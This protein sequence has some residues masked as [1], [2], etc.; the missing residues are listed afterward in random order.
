VAAALIHSPQVVFLDE[1]TAGLDV[2]SAR[3][4]RSL[5]R[6]INRD[7][8]TVFLTTHNLAEAESLSHRILILVRGQLVAEG[9]AAEI[10]RQVE[11]T[12]SLSVRF[13]ADVSERMLRDACPDVRSISLVEGA[14]RLEVTDVHRATAQLL[15]FADEH[16]VRI[17]ELNTSTPSLED[18]FMTILKGDSGKEEAPP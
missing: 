10:R 15:S 2:P 1:P 8:A 17:L 13:D 18:A 16:G 12:R 9:T 14:W 4:L 3:A 5:I 6:T 11:R 7:G